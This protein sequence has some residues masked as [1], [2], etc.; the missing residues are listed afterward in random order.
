MVSAPSGELSSTPT[1]ALSSKPLAAV[2]SEPSKRSV[3]PSPEHLWCSQHSR[4][5]VSNYQNLVV[6]ALE[7]GLGFG[8]QLGFK[9]PSAIARHGNINLAVAGQNGLRADAIAVIATAAP[10]WI[11]FFVAE[12]FGQ[13]RPESPLDQGLLQLFEKPFLAKQIFRLL[14]I[15]K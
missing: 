3:S 12:M 8:G 1:S 15:N 7:A 11:A 2:P 9:T 14:I 13:F 6:K 5:E 10:S 4:R